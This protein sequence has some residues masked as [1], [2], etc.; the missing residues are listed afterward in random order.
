MHARLLFA[1]ALLACS[2]GARAEVRE[3]TAEAA[4]ITISKPI[5]ATP[6]KVWP[7]LLGVSHW[8]GDAYTFSGKAENLDLAARAGSCFCERWGDGASAEHGRVLLSLP[9]RLLR[10]STVVGPLQEFAYVGTLD[11]WLKYAEDG[12]AVLDLEYRIRGAGGEL[13]ELAP[14]IDAQLVEQVGRLARYVETGSAELPEAAALDGGVLP[15]PDAG[16]AARAAI[17]EAWKKSAERNSLHPAVSPAPPVAPAPEG[18]PP[19]GR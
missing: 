14:D 18:K 17:L 7:A 15:P 3:A 6:E 1:A 9:G 10:L 12:S 8:W 5:A 19:A 2:S 13:D 11:F 16:A 4:F